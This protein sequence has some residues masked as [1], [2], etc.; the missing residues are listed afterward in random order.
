M[1]ELLTNIYNYSIESENIRL[2]IY[3]LITI[4]VFFLIQKLIN[5]FFLKRI[6]TPIYRILWKR[7][8]SYSLFFI[9]IFIVTPLWLP[10]LQA[11]SAFL[12]LFGAGILIIN[13][14]VV[15]NIIGW[16]YIVIRQPFKLANRIQIGD[17][18]GDVIDIRIF[19][20]TLM[21]T[22]KRD[23]GGLTTGRVL[24]VPNMLFLITPMANAS[25]EFIFNWNELSVHL[26]YDSNWKKAKKILQKIAD[27]HIERLSSNA[28]EMKSLH[29]EYMALIDNIKHEIFIE[30]NEDHIIMKLRYLI[31][32][33]SSG[34]ITS[35]LWEDILVEFKK[36]HDIKYYNTSE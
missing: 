6:T 18:T 13:K 26:S 21:E 10:S 22:K 27:N 31:E 1:K 8:V 2:V 15:M 11:F 16:M 23:E 9:F 7:I 34:K 29:T 5:R 28:T 19:E 3:T 33:R 36:H 30:L 25:K 4:A 20:T 35:Y 32:P 14:E 24:H 12:G 17:L